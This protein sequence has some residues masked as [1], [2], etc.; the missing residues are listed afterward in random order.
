MRIFGPK[1][2]SS[3][4]K[5]LCHA[6]NSNFQLSL[7]FYLDTDQILKVWSPNRSLSAN[8]GPKISPV[9]AG[10]KNENW[11]KQKKITPRDN[12]KD[13]RNIKSKPES[14][15]W[16]ET[17]APKFLRKNTPKYP[18]KG[19]GAKGEGGSN[20]FSSIKTLTVTV[21]STVCNMEVI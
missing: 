14:L 20:F 6:Q 2:V 8:F 15:K 17:Y 1:K 3:T 4:K 7:G 11:A 19:A 21:E 5:V 12:P 10:P 16:A 13:A 18:K 9:P